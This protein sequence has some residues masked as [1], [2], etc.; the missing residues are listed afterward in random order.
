MTLHFKHLFLLLFIGAGLYSCSPKIVGE[1]PLKVERRKTEELTIKLDSLS[2][3]VPA[4]FYSK[5]STKYTDTN[6]NLS[7]KTSVTILKD[8]AFTALVTYAGIPIINAYINTDSLQFTNKKDKC[9]TKTTLTHLKDQFGV[10]FDFQNLQ[11]LFL[12]LPLNYQSSAKYYQIHNPFDYIISNYK[13]R[14]IRKLERKDWDDFIIK[15]YLNPDLKTLK[16]LIIENPK[17]NNYIVVNYL[18]YQVENGFSIPLEVSID[19][20]TDKN[21]IEVQ[22]EY[23]K[24]EINE[25]QDIFFTIP[26]SYEVCQ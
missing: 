12:G 18:K 24:V 13:K 2:K 17:D 20:R 19:I 11:Q 15:Y 21:H 14:E 26:E 25:P 4:T 22:L 1:Q 9:Y 5:I 8:S 7:F 16:K 6:Q 10:A 23:D 3:Q